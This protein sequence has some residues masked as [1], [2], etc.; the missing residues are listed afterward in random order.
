MKVMTWNRLIPSF[1]QHLSLYSVKNRNEK[2]QRRHGHVARMRVAVPPQVSIHL[3]SGIW[4][5]RL[6]GWLVGTDLPLTEAFISQVSPFWITIFYAN[7]PWLTPE[8]NMVKPGKPSIFQA[9]LWCLTMCFATISQGKTAAIPGPGHS[10]KTAVQRAMQLDRLLLVDARALHR[11]QS[12][13]GSHGQ[14]QAD[15]RYGC[16]MVI[17]W[18]LYG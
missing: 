15:S 1:R 12:V 17:I 5:N 10:P 14:I 6:H 13:S 9:K 3:V 7:K 11:P 18:L 2:Y 4:N 16:Y 8:Q